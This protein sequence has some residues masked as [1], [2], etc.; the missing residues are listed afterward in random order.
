[1]LNLTVTVTL[2]PV[3]ATRAG[4]SVNDSAEQQTFEGFEGLAVNQLEG[5]VAAFNI[6]LEKPLRM[7]EEVEFRGRAV[8]SE[9]VFG[10]DKDKNGFGDTGRRK[11]RLTPVEVILIRDDAE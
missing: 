7:F 10:A 4:E 2:S 5:T 1:M 3:M 8:V 6:V 11:V 9:V